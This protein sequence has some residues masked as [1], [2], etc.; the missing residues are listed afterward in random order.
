MP[1][2]VVI[3]YRP[4]SDHSREVEQY[5]VDFGRFHPDGDLE[6]LSVET[7]DGSEKAALYAVMQYPA[8]LALKDD[9]QMEHIWADGKLP[10]MND[11]AYYA[12]Q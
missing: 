2:K 7:K 8:V 3:L 5:A 11:L 6:L 4:E 1:M 12:K 10:L 9:G